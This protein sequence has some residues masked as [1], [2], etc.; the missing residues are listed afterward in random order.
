MS[1]Y[2]QYR[3]VNASTFHITVRSEREKPFALVRI[4]SVGLNP[5]DVKYLYGDK[6]PNFCL[7][8]LKFLL[9]RRPCGFDFS[10]IIVEAPE[11][12]RFSNG[13]EVLLK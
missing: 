8:I 10:G 9:H 6:L 2:H 3:C 13:D 7:P 4:L 1:S 11:D 12:C 5:V